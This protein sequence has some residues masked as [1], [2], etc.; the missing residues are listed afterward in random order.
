MRHARFAI[1]IGSI[2]ILASCGRAAG[3]AG[4]SG[5]T[6]SGQKAEYPAPRYPSYG[7]TPKTVDQ[8]M[9]FA[10]DAVRQ[11]GGRTPLGLVKQ[12]QTV[13]IV[14]RANDNDL[15]LDGIKKA[16]E[17]RGVKVQMAF[18]S[19]LAGVKRADALELEK[20]IGFDGSN[21][22]QEVNFWIENRFADIKAPKEWLKSKDPKLYSALYPTREI[23]DRLKDAAEK[24]NTERPTAAGI[25][26][27]LDQHP[28][29]DVVFWAKGGRPSHTKALGD[30]YGPKFYGNWIYG[31]VTELMSKVPAFPSDVW[32]LAEQRTIEPLNFVDR[33]KVS[34]PEGT[35]FQFDLSEHL[36][37]VWSKGVYLQG[38]LFML[39][40]Q[41]T[42]RF[43][44]SVVDYPAFTSKWLPPEVVLANGTFAGHANH[45]GVFPTIKVTVKDGYVSSVEGGGA[46]GDAW[47]AFL[48]Y[49]KINEA[50]WPLYKDDPNYKQGYFYLYE[51]G[52]GTNPKFYNSPGDPGQ[53]NRGGTVHWGFGLRV[54]NGPESPYEPGKEWTDWTTQNNLPDDHWWHIHNFFLTY[55]V[56]I[57]G[58]DK[59]VVLLDKGHLTALD[60]PEVR[61]LA[62][63]YG[64]PATILADDFVPDVPGVNAPG[65]YQEFAKDP[66]KRY[67][68]VFKQAEAGTYP[69]LFPKPQK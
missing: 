56:R 38:H 19:E 61:A 26:A 34:D 12:G 55:Q 24:L 11:T 58:T 25:I 31:Q 17:E 27:Y 41:A 35:D 52:L 1:L 53:R 10:R 9:P 36:A 45:H 60:N 69:Y 18:D 37:D 54:D 47:R 33:V 39:P 4:S 66:W 6:P 50:K 8:V 20:I 44:Y 64:D 62:S 49:P 43:P 21:G 48:Q 13:F 42:G 40:V 29:V 15:L 30:K 57:R 46:Y 28:E 3:P 67:Q 16:Y 14:A 63:R 22:E 68:E 5:A 2:F 23:P 65:S 59:Q 51:A 32:R 7:V